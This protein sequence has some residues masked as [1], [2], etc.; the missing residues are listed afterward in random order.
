MTKAKIATA[1][2]LILVVA[3]GYL[4]LNR[5]DDVI[6]V[7][8]E[9][10]GSAAMGVPVSVD[11][12]ITDLALG[13]ATIYGLSIANPEGYSSE[14][15]MNIGLIEASVDYETFDIK[16]INIS[17]VLVNA[18][19]KGKQNNF[20]T[21]V[22]NMPE[23]EAVEE[24]GEPTEFKIGQLKIADAKVKL[25]IDK[26]GDA[27]FKMDD[28]VRTDIEGSDAEISDYLSN[29]LINHISAQIKAH[30]RNQLNKILKGVKYKAT[31]TLKADLSEKRAELTDKVGEKLKGFK[32][33]LGS[34]D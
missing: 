8:I 13:T 6:A 30:T 29:E 27:S 14:P 12:V 32:L 31:E 16:E 3:L 18:E 4:G 20:E 17:Q 11:K 24:A 28:F 34:K 33:K 10:E 21:M 9:E 7:T 25:H 15:A 1:V 2:I 22:D 23:D 26:I 5:L 19:L